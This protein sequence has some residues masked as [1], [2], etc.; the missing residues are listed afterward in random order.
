[1]AMW[2]T[3]KSF[4]ELKK[5]TGCAGIMIGRGALGNPQIFSDILGNNYPYSKKDCVL[6]HIKELQKIYSDD[7]IAKHMRKHLLWYFGGKFN[8][9]TFKERAI[10]VQ[11]VDEIKNLVNEFFD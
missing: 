1:M 6:N 9:K 4:E 11:S 10:K 7:F 5:Q 3:K 8:A 2:W